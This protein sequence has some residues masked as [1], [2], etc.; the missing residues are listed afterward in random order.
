MARG[1][2]PSAAGSAEVQVYERASDQPLRLIPHLTHHHV[3]GLHLWIG[4]EDGVLLILDGEQNRFF[5]ELRAAGCVPARLL[6]DGGGSEARW[7]AIVALVEKCAEAGF[8]EDIDGYHDVCRTAPERFARLHL[9]ARCQL[10][11]VHCY[12]ASG[13]EADGSRELTPEHWRRIIDDIS[14]AG[15]RSVLFTGG[16][17]LIRDDCASL[18]RHASERGSKSR[19]SPTVCWWKSAFP[20]SPGP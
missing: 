10:R 7:N 15:G 9:T 16:E 19:C 8:L 4:V 17:P 3:D 20:R 18:M 2:V 6:A 11:C 1:A 13:P 5:E 12:A 14:E